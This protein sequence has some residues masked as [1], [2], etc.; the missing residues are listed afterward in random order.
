MDQ[1][2]PRARSSR[3]QTTLLS[4][5]W[6]QKRDLGRTLLS[7]VRGSAPLLSGLYHH[8]ATGL[9]SPATRGVLSTIGRF[10]DHDAG[11]LVLCQV[12]WV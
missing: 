9:P 1:Q 4:D 11:G 8:E 10:E 6:V 7:Y 12:I 5:A 2:N 3:H